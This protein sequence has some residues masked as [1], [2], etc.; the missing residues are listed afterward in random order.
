MTVNIAE[1]FELLFDKNNKVAYKA[2]QELQK[3]SEEANCVYPY[4]DRLSDMLDSDNSYIRTRGLTLIAY[5]AKWDKDYKIDEI[6]D[7]YLRHITDVKPIT[8]RQ[9]IKLL[10]IIV[11]YK[12]ELRND[13]LSALHKANLCIYDDSMQPL[14]YKDIQK[15]LKEIQGL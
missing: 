4:M 5:N 2:L 9:C 12:P 6:I 3:E 1:T 10:S 15:V 14:V 8:A 13:I 11:K 7:K